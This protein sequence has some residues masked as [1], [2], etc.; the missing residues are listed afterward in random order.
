[1]MRHL[2]SGCPD[3]TRSRRHIPAFVSQGLRRS[4]RRILIGDGRGQPGRGVRPGDQRAGQRAARFVDRHR[5]RRPRHGLHGQV[6]ARPGH[7]HRADAARRRG[8]V[9]A[10]R[11][12]TL[13]QCDTAVT[14]DQGTTSGASR[15]DQLQSRQSRAGGRDRARGA[16]AAGV[17]RGS[18]CQRPIWL[19]ENG[20]VTRQGDRREA[21]DLRRAGRREEVRTAARLE[22][23][24]RKH[25]ASGRC[26][27]RRCRAS[28]CRAWRP[29]RVRVRPQRSRAGHAARRG[30]AAAG[31]G[32]HARQRRRRLGPRACPASSRSSS[33][34]NFVGVVAEKPWQ[35]MQAASKLEG[36]LDARH[37]LAAA[38]R[39]LRL[40][41]EAARRATRS[42]STPGRRRHAGG[43]G[44][45]C[46]RRPICI[47][48]R[49]TARS[50]RRARSPT[51]RAA[52]RRVWSATQ[53]AYPTRSGVAM[54]L[55]CRP[56]TSASSSRA[57]PAATAST[58]P[59]RCRTT[60]RCCRRR[61]GGRCACSSR[62]RTKWP[63]RT[64]AS[65][66][67][68]DQRVGARRRRHDLRVGL[69]GVVAPLAAA[70]P[71][72]TRPATSSPAC[73]PGS[74]PRRSRRDARAAPAGAFNN[75]SNAAP[76]YVA[77]RVGGRPRR[78]G[79]DRERARAR[80]T[81]SRRRSSPVR[82]VRR[83]G[84]RTR[85]RTS[86]SSTK[87]RRT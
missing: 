74:S 7:L 62:A 27:A 52:R 2:S 81:P 67:S 65:P 82:C 40:P 87:W 22:Q 11:S 5:R 69:R 39:V 9:R 28:T 77:G 66:T 15:P 83:R 45:A 38:A 50:A 64:T 54:L 44:D 16:A 3:R 41:A 84:C 76:S 13:I 37:R 26:S 72:T 48:I 34:S 36:D 55:G 4:G 61:S 47:R 23:P 8:A 53:S 20:V 73:S 32:R 17:E 51:C 85:S 78:R 58:A 63:G 19:R 86:A 79:H 14:P 71:A 31:G 49:C 75:G 56:T 18:A 60:R 42:S 10:A 25:R 12:R 1:M 35:A 70:G 57:A 21:R 59:T 24:Q 43:G 68:I 30:G 6:R 29:G 33:R 80:R 46:S